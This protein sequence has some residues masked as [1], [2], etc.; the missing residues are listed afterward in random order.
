MSREGPIEKRV[1]HY[2]LGS[3]VRAFG[4]G[5]FEVPVRVLRY[6]KTA[7]LTLDDVVE[8]VTGLGSEDFHKSQA[9]TR[10]PGVWLDIY[11]PRLRGRR[12]Y[13]KFVA[14]EDGWRLVLLSFCGDGDPH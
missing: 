10:R 5:R 14:H 7:E 6:L 4:E 1:P 11:R 9:H 3:V 12:M 13:V 2:E 8:C